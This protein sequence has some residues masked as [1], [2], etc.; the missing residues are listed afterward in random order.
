MVCP[1]FTSRVEAYNVEGIDVLPLGGGYI[2]PLMNWTLLILTAERLE[3]MTG[4][5][6]VLVMPAVVT[7]VEA[8][9]NPFTLTDDKLLIFTVFIKLVSPPLTMRPPS[10]YTVDAYMVEGVALTDGP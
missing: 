4:R 8:V 2:W 1:P 5:P 10:I 3:V 7:R 9:N 6:P